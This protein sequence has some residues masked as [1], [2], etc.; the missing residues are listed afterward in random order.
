MI[1]AHVG[2]A[3]NTSSVMAKFNNIA[4]VIAIIV[5]EKQQVLLTKRG[6]DKSFP[7]HWEFPGGKVEEGELPRD[8]LIREMREELDIAVSDCAP[9]YQFEYNYPEFYVDFICFKVNRYE[10]QA[11][12]KEDQADMMFQPIDKLSELAFPQ[13]NQEII[14]KLIRDSV[15]EVI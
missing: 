13:A 15:V 14:E 9:W 10:G 12:I 4:V 7:L 3:K 1:L 8:A 2:V 5:D 6:K 11:T